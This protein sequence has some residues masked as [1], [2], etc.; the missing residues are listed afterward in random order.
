MNL[1]LRFPV[2]TV[3]EQRAADIGPLHFCSTAANLV[4]TDECPLT[5][6]FSK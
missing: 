3:P 1:L 2:Y 5:H 6:T 4:S